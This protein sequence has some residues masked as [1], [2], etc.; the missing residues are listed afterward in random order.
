MRKTLLIFALISLFVSCKKDCYECRWERF[1]GHSQ[2]KYTVK[3]ERYCDYDD[4]KAH[5]GKSEYIVDPSGKRVLA[6]CTCTME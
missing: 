5:D 4:V 2:N 1:Y 6:T 3:Q